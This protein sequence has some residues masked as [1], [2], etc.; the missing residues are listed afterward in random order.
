MNVN[1]LIDSIVRQTT[2]L[3]A[4]LA[5]AGGGRPSLAHTANQVFV[6]LVRELRDQGVGNKVI[7]DM[8][9]MALRTYHDRV[10]RLEESSTYSGRSLWEAVL[11]FVQDKGTVLQND[12]L[13]RFR[14]DDNLT[15]RG[16][17]NDLVDSG[18]VFRTGRGTRTA[19]RAASAEEVRLPERDDEGHSLANLVWV[20]INRLGPTNPE[21]I[22][23]VVPVDVGAL[24]VALELLV[25]DGR[26][27]R[28]ERAGIIEYSCDGCVIPVGASHGWEASVFDHY[29]AV[30]TAIGTKL[31]NP[32]KVDTRESV[33]GSTYNYWVW[34]NHPMRDEVVGLLGQLRERAVDLRQRLDAYNAQQNVPREAMTRVIAYVGQTVLE[35]EQRASEE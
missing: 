28:T 21:S 1:L 34:D 18:M 5:T 9:G 6:S 32:G 30:V 20:A 35:P 14:N 12:V 24:Q 25:K 33:G 17:L 19:F 11:E 8:F 22:V 23:E 10:R 29:Q 26:V 31:R 2:V 7:A 3:I 4:Q 13:L 16:V 15:V 27:T